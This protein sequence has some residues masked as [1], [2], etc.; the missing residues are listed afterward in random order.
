MGLCLQ[1]S[2]YLINRLPTSSLQ[3]QVPYTVLFHKS[4]DYAFLRNFGCSCYPFLC[5]YNKHKLEFRSHECL[6]L[7]Y[8]PSHK[9]YKCLSSSGRLYVSKDVAFNELKYPF[10]DLFLTTSNKYVVS[11]IVDTLPSTT[12]PI[13]SSSPSTPAVTSQFSPP[14]NTNSVIIPHEPAVIA[15]GSG[16]SLSSV[17]HSSPP[18]LSPQNI[19]PMQT[20]SK[21]GVFKPKVHP[22]FLLTTCEPNSVKQA[23]ADPAWFAAM[24]QEFQALIDNNTW[25]LVTLPN[26]RQPVSC[27]WVFRIK[28]NVDGSVKRYKARLVAKGFHQVAVCDFT[29]TFSLVIKPVTIRLILT[30]AVTNKWD[31]FQLDVNNAFLNG[32]LQ[33]TIYMQQPPGFDSGDKSMVCKLNKAIYGFKQAPRQ[34]FQRL[35]Q[36][37]L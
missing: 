30:L 2:V 20:K 16:Q 18:H 10:L 3:F 9:G 14:I 11:P 32:S 5:S 36:I 7:G 34:W 22:S 25:D 35:K 28:E 24:K 6:F 21:A 13:V 23:L 31:L 1:T 4:P 8:S 27:K 29:E 12:I 19:H 15:P 26:D 37:L 33:E 17:S